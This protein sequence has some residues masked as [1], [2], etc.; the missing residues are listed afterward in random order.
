MIRYSTLAYRRSIAAQR[1]AI[2]SV[3][4][5]MQA[6]WREEDRKRWAKLDTYPLR[7]EDQ[8]ASHENG[9]IAA[10]SIPSAQSEFRLAPH[11]WRSAQMTVRSAPQQLRSA[12][13]RQPGKAIPNVFNTGANAITQKEHS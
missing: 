4:P 6:H 9:P 5:D 3:G 10:D 12:Q 8:P 2:V 13:K 7:T 11:A 1:D